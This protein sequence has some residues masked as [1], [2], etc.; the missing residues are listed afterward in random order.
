MVT[1][2]IRLVKEIGAGGMGSIWVA[3]HLALQTQVVVKFMHAQIA[4][5]PQSLERFKREAAAA[6]NVKSPHVVQVLDHG[7]APDGSPYI[8][9]ELLEGVDLAAWLAQHAPLPLANVALIVAQVCKALARAHER[10]IVH[11]DIKPQNVFLSQVGEGEPFVKVL[12]FGIAK[13]PAA[14]SLS[15]A[16]KTG[17]L[18]G[19]PYYMSPEQ[20]LGAK[21]IDHR[22]DLW[23]VGVVAFEAMTGRP[24]FVAETIGGLAVAICNGPIP[25]PS[26]VNPAILPAVDAWFL[27]ACARDPAQR[28]QSARELSDALQLAVA[29][30]SQPAFAAA[31]MMPSASVSSL[32]IPQTTNAPMSGTRPAGVPE[33]GGM[34]LVLVL[35]GLLLCGGIAAFVVGVTHRPAPSRPPALVANGATAEGPAAIASTAVA[36][37]AACIALPPLEPAAPAV[38][39]R[40]TRTPPAAPAL[41]ISAGRTKPATS[42]SSTSAPASAAPP[43]KPP[44][45]AKTDRFSID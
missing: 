11:R 10:G 25:R 22:T 15:G 43:A 20:T 36:T 2:S 35:G 16:T 26:S 40:T 12:D 32:G 27:R 5:D 18:M 9:M 3:D 44:A 24:P 21:G 17:A 7:V 38:P 34:A 31:P 1:S 8:V 28:F 30:T 45:S 42:L 4:Q 37:P 33:R 41:K 39:E 13:A 29:S 6:A 14:Q 23:A 19:T